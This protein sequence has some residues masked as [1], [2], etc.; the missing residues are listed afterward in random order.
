MTQKNLIKRLK[1]AFSWENS[2][3]KGLIIFSRAKKTFLVVYPANVVRYNTY[4]ILTRGYDIKI[5]DK[6]LS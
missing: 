3:V 4:H 6:Y 1:N 5:I 2:A